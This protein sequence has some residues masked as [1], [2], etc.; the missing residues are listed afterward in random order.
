MPTFA[1]VETE[2]LRRDA[3]LCDMTHFE[4]ELDIVT[5][6]ETQE[7]TPTVTTFIASLP[8]ITTTTKR[9]F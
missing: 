9:N 5:P 8:D 4:R 7:R 2:A 3:A 1:A 6:S